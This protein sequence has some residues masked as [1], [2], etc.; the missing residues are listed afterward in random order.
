[1]S[2][3][4]IRRQGWLNSYLTVSMARSPGMAY[5]VSQLGVS[6]GYNQGIG[7]AA[8]PSG[9]LSREESTSRLIQVVG[10]I[11]IPVAVWLMLPASY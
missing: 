7:W 9:D 6:Q 1:M 5:P 3:T 2:V 8:F 10:R 4:F 11:H